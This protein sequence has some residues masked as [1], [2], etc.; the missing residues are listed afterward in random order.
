LYQ[1]GTDLKCLIKLNNNPL[2]QNSNLAKYNI[3]RNLLK[4]LLN[5]LKPKNI[6]FSKEISRAQQNFKKGMEFNK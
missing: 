4:K 3:Y 5:L 1:C 2:I 6:F